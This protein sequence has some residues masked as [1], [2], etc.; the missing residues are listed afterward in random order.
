MKAKPKRIET[1]FARE[2]GFSIRPTPAALSRRRQEK[3]LEAL[4][5][6]L[7]AQLTQPGADPNLL[8][9]LQ[10]A[11]TDAAALAWLTPCP[12]LFFPLLFEEKVR[13]ARQY[14]HRQRR[15]RQGVGSAIEQAA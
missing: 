11:A 12:A 2:R 13:A 4:K 14:L 7:L 10:R 8:K 1:K 9:A 3:Q 6:V 5:E 15:I